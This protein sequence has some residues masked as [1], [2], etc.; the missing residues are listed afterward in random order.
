[1][2]LIKTTWDKNIQ[3]WNLSD[4]GTPFS[5]HLQYADI[6]SDSISADTFNIL[7][8]MED[9]GTLWFMFLWE[10][11]P[12]IRTKHIQFLNNYSI[13]VRAWYSW[14][15]LIYLFLLDWVGYMKF[16]HAR[17]QTNSEE[18]QLHEVHFRFH[19]EWFFRRLHRTTWLTS[20]CSWWRRRSITLKYKTRNQ[21]HMAHLI[22]LERSHDFWERIL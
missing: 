5:G 21:G 20:C 18:Q 11:A 10:T 8:L 6:L 15:F 19:W 22:G 12:L 2:H 17:D 4:P 13:N 9:F 1:M 16:A 7:A 14:E 3:E